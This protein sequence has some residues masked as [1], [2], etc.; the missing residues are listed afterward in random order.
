LVEDEA[1]PDATPFLVTGTGNVG[2]GTTT[3]SSGYGSGRGVM[4]SNQSGLLFLN[5]SGVWST[6]ATGGAV[7]YFS[8]N[9]LYLDAKDS[10]SNI[11]F[12]V[13]GANERMR[14]TSA[15]SVGVGATPASS[16]SL[17][18]GRA[19][20][21]ATSAIGVL[22]NGTVVSDV[23]SSADLFRTGGGT[24]AASFTLGTMR[25]YYAL[26]GTFG[27]S[28]A[29]TDQI[30][31]LAESTLTGATNNYGFYSNIASGTGRWNFF[32]NG[33]ANNYFAGNV[34]IG[35]TAPGGRLEVQ[36]AGSTIVDARLRINNPNT[37]SNS[38]AILDLY[39]NGRTRSEIYGQQDGTG[40][41]GFFILNTTDSAGAL[42]ERMR[43]D[44]QGRVG[45]GST[46]LAG[47]NVRIQSSTTGAT[48]AAC[49]VNTPTILSDVTNLSYNFWSQPN[50][51]AASFSLNQL[52]HYYAS[53]GTIG[54]ASSIVNQY[55]YT[56]HS[57]MIGA[58]NNFGFYG[59]IPA[60]TGRWNFYAD[61]T[62]PNYFAGNVGVGT[63]S[64]GTSA[65]EVL[66]IGTG[67]APTTGPADTIQIY[68]T[69][70][71]AGNTMLSIYTEGTSV[72]ANTTAAATHRIAVRINGTVY[73]LLANTSA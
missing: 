52:Y 22:S 58:T 46:S 60:G 5:A 71:S 67:V 1:N 15:G 24:Q 14:I 63:T 66:A 4:L 72:N 19:I 34:G 11:I 37:S 18:V 55:G 38:T 17:Q 27:A 73:Y 28:S 8:D 47:Y 68:S 20:T 49:F 26:Q 40:N 42:Q 13:N 16:T 62:A 30:G 21:N 43:I 51:Q 65:Q 12:R 59:N 48:S 35:T 25:H 7:T 32:A 50:T 36:G 61:G 69:D 53:Q 23:T 10:A 3:T 45:I 41:G 9:N 64:F 31:F 70:L 6:T 39:A 54:A 29:V 33:T 56:A 2:I 44:S 57:N